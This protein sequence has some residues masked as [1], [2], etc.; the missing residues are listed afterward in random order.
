MNSTESYFEDVNFT[1]IYIGVVLVGRF[2]MGNRF[3]LL[4]LGLLAT[5]GNILTLAAFV[6]FEKLRTSRYMMVASLA[7]CDTMIGSEWIFRSLTAIFSLWCHLEIPVVM[8]IT[9]TS[10]VSHVHVLLM[11]VDRF[12]ALTA[13]FRHAELMSSRRI[14]SM[15]AAG[16]I[17]GVTYALTLLCWGWKEYHRNCEYLLVPKIYI[18]ATQFSMYIIAIILI[19]A[20]YCAVWRVAKRQA[21]RTNDVGLHREARAERGTGQMASGI[22]VATTSGQAKATKFISIVLGVYLGTWLLY[23]CYGVISVSPLRN[24]NFL[25][26]A[27]LYEVAM[28]LMA[29][30]SCLNIFIYAVY[31]KE[32]RD[33][34]RKLLSCKSRTVLPVNT[35]NRD[36]RNVSNVAALSVPRITE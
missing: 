7:V 20:M 14:L 31:L 27:V 30:N 4:I 25:A 22:Q 36:T 23:M 18:G 26:Q 3:I 28:D 1:I 33:A 24:A 12:I 34:Y 9:A 17:F 2:I 35:L 8:S 32:F 11:A 21:A 13:P 19:A 5:A 6:K 16:W 10:G 29:L 15:I